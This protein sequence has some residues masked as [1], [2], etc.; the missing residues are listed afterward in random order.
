MP[1]VGLLSKPLDCIIA[2]LRSYDS[3]RIENPAKVAS[4]VARIM[5]QLDY[6][7]SRCHKGGMDVKT[8][9]I[10]IVDNE[11]LTR[12]KM[13]TILEREGYHVFA[14]GSANEAL[15]QAK[16]ED[17]DLVLADIV[18]PC[19]G[20]LELVEKL[21]EVSPDTIPLL[22]RG[23]SDIET[24]RAAM[25]V[26]VYDCIVDPVE[27]SEL[28]TAIAKALRRRWLIKETM[29]RRQLINE[30]HHRRQLF[31]GDSLRK[32]LVEFVRN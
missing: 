26:G 5:L 24:A 28:C 19:N 2:G 31:E 27:R 29:R 6:R 3:L 25:R 32:R 20:E 22:I 8:E 11:P 16:K 9:R 12:V 15:R 14:V 17:F 23:Y 18:K 21:R 13:R 10:L 1:F 4:A 30:A 7:G